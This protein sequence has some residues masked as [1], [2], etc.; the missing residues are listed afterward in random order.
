MGLA[1]TMWPQQATVPRRE[2]QGPL[3][4]SGWSLIPPQN[5]LALYIISHGSIP[6]RGSQDY[7]LPM[8]SFTFP[9]G[10]LKPVLPLPS[11]FL[12][13]SCLFQHKS[14][15]PSAPGSIRHSQGQLLGELKA[16]GWEIELQLSCFL[17][18]L[19]TASRNQHPARFPSFPDKQP[20]ELLPEPGE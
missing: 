1:H 6:Q 14:R 7:P 12:P 8:P 13:W 15:Q 3:D 11:R 16:K 5:F 10:K 2:V 19:L 18:T 20:H 17:Q 4:F 9:L